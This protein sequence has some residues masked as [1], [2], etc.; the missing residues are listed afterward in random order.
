MIFEAVPAQ[1][2]PAFKCQHAHCAER[3]IEHFLEAAEKA[4]PGIINRRCASQR[5]R[6]R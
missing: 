5:Q 4:A 1:R 3:T 6:G 2:L